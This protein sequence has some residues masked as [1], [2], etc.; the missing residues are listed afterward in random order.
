ML[1]KFVNFDYDII[2]TSF[3]YLHNL[4]LETKASK[5]TQLNLM[6]KRRIEKEIRYFDRDCPEGITITQ[7]QQDELTFYAII[8][9]P[10]DTAYQGGKFKLQIKLSP[11]F[12]FKPPKII[13]LTP[14]YHPSIDPTTGKISLDILKSD[15]ALVSP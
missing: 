2:K 4:T 11:D 6:N 3:F 10:D 15:W 8:M 1:F 5:S 14:V 12:P 9:G 7:S 13:F